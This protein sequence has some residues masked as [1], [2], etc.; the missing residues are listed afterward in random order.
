LSSLASQHNDNTNDRAAFEVR[1]SGVAARRAQASYNNGSAAFEVRSSGVAR[2]P[3]SNNNYHTASGVA[4]VSSSNSNGRA[5]FEAHSSGVAARILAKHDFRLSD[6]H[7]LGNAT[8]GREG[9][10]NP[11]YVM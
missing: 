10:I 6:G 11:M 2:A 1:L 4:R 8:A 3:S 7:G 5:A 9:I